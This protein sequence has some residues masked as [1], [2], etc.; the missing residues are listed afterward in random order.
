MRM[1]PVVVFCWALVFLTVAFVWVCV[2][3]QNS[4]AEVRV[5][6]C[7]NPAPALPGKPTVFL[8][9]CQTREWV[10]VT[11]TSVVASVSQTNPQWK[12]TY[13]GYL[14]TDPLVACPAGA[15]VMGSQCTDATGAEVSQVIPKSA[16]PAFILVPRPVPAD[17]TVRIQGVTDPNVAATF[18]GLDSAQVQCFVITTGTKTGQ[19]CL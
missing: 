17:Y 2:H 9:T 1:R 7:S 3:A 19:V 4:S 14:P 16:V 5:L 12:H 11:T 6:G 13:A 8:S 10:P 15:N 18:K